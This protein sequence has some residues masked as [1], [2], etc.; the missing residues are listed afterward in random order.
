MIITEQ[1]I[2]TL[3]RIAEHYCSMLHRHGEATS[4]E[5]IQSFL[6]NINDQ[7]SDELKKVK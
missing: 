3:L 1:Q 2:L 7:Q 6:A 5:E 4:V